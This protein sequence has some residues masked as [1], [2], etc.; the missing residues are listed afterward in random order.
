MPPRGHGHEYRSCPGPTLPDAGR[1]QWAREVS[2]LAG[3]AQ[4][5][6]REPI[7]TDDLLNLRIVLETSKDVTDVIERA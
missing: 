6:G 3:H 7:S 2:A 4:Y 1:A 5:T